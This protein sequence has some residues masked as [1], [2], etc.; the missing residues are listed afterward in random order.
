M[1]E[2]SALLN[3]QNHGRPAVSAESGNDH[4]EPS[5]KGEG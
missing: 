4:E 3:P 2:A 5:V 1:P